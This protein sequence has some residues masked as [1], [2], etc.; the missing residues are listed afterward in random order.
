MTISYYK[1]NVFFT[2][3][4]IKGHT[5]ALTSTGRSG[6][7]NKDKTAYMAIVRVTELF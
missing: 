2:A 1:T 3:A 5:R 6:F 7:K 4:D